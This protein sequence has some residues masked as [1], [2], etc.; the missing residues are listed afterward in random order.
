MKSVLL[1]ETTLH[2]APND[3]QYMRKTTADQTTHSLGDCFLRSHGKKT[4][5]TG[6]VPGIPAGCKVNNVEK[7]RLSTEEHQNL[8]W[9]SVSKR[10]MET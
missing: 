5:K 3:N 6:W 10:G 8:D 1:H 4:L 7:L 9:K 2:K